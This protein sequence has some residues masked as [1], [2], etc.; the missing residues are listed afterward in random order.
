M[1]SYPPER[2]P[3]DELPQ[4]GH[5][6]LR[7]ALSTWTR[8]TVPPNCSLEQPLKSHRLR[9]SRRTNLHTPATRFAPVVNNNRESPKGTILYCSYLN[10]INN[11]V[12][13]PT[14]QK[15]LCHPLTQ[16]RNL[17]VIPD[18]PHFLF[19]FKPHCSK[20]CHS[21]P[22]TSEPAHCGHPVHTASAA[23]MAPAA[24]RSPLLLRVI[25]P[26]KLG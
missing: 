10:Q 23:G 17:A 16:A 14:F 19:S 25:L 7:E 21:P 9:T 13:S 8:S 26:L 18:P 20:S 2:S 24:A 5:A 4:R 3:T 11:G 15:A 12:S 1:R 6:R 22:N